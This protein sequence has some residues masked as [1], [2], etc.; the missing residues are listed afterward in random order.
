VAGGGVTNYPP[1]CAFCGKPC[2]PHAV[3]AFV[4]QSGWSVNRGPRGGSNQ[5]NLRRE[6]GCYAHGACIRLAVR[7]V[8]PRDQGA[9]L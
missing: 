8:D 3:G 1:V 6:T 5:L 9:M 4:E 7:G 2:N